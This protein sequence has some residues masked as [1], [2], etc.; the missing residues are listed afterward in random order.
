MWDPRVIRC[1]SGAGSAGGAAGL[2]GPAPFLAGGGRARGPA[3]PEAEAERAV[4][5]AH[6]GADPGLW[7]GLGRRT[8][9]AFRAPGDEG[10]RC[11]RTA[12]ARGL[13]HT[14]P[15]TEP[16]APAPASHRLGDPGAAG[17]L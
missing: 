4:P 15:G 3:P 14:H 6:P 1:V 17:T 8:A 10:T 7:R 12:A 9:P 5:R 2:L 13:P 11:D 16:E